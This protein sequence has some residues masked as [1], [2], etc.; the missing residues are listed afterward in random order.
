MRQ[1]RH[2]E[3]SGRLASAASLLN[4]PPMTVIGRSALVSGIGLMGGSL[5]A[6][7]SRRGW[8]VL[9]HHRRPEVARQAE[10]LG[11]GTA[12]TGFDE[13]HDADVAII[14]TPVGAIA[15]SAWAIASATRCVITDVGST[16]ER[17]CDDLAPLA[18]RFIGSHPMTGSHQQGL[19]HADPDLYAGCVTIVT[20]TAATPS[21]LVDTIDGLWRAV[22]SRVVRL[23]PATHD[24]AVAEASH[25]PHLLAS[26][27]AAQLGEDAAPL[28]AGGFRDTTRVAAGSPLLWSDI[29]VH[30]A[31]AVG[32]GIDATVARLQELRTALSRGDR[33]AVEAWLEAGR[34]G[35]CRY[36][37][38]TRPR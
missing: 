24:R 32:M 15:D 35:R 17:I 28:A 19:E 1:N 22:G 11:Y 13:A 14:C 20:P 12:I 30:N 8:R 38:I 27:A 18:D 37:D 31:E 6:A 16:K 36:D 4:L 34:S 7:L 9:L 3:A 23:D 10:K 5:A 25:V 29:L 26:A 2:P 21:E 33:A